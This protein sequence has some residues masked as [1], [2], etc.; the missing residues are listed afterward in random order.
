MF[1]HVFPLYKIFRLWDTLL[2][3]SSAFPLCIGAAILKQLRNILLNSDFNECI[4]LFSELPEINIE[5]CVTDSINLF[6][7]TPSSCLYREHSTLNPTVSEEPELEMSP[8]G[9][10]QMRAELCPRVSAKDILG[11]YDSKMSKIVLIDLRPSSE[12][13]QSFL[14]K[15]KNFPYEQINF[16]KL[17]QIG[18]NQISNAPNENDS[19]LG[20][21]YLLQ[22][23]RNQ[24]KIL[25]TWDECVNEK[26]VD[27]ANRLVRLKFSKICILHKGIESLRSTK[28]Y[29]FV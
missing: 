20:L 16:N 23:A 27:L 6:C 4:L 10:E 25:V 21:I 2:L 28:I 14:L 3:G 18:L 29:Q 26:A 13:S 11:L 15:S 9:L 17:E 8:I 19:T 22:Q 1:A 24:V 12:F 5:K 7:K